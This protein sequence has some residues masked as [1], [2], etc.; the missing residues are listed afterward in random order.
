MAKR[1]EDKPPTPAQVVKRAQEYRSVVKGKWT[2]KQL[3]IMVLLSD[4]FG[5]SQKVI[6]RRVGVREEYIS[7]L[8]RRRSFLAD[9]DRVA[10]IMFSAVDIMI[11]RATARD[12]ALPIDQHPDVAASITRNRELYLKRRGKLDDVKVIKTPDGGSVANVIAVVEVDRDEAAALDEITKPAPEKK[13]RR[14]KK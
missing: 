6:A 2:P 4:P 13:S 10:D 5:V 12:A 1:K 3:A 7:R 14:K 8:K 9:M 11:D